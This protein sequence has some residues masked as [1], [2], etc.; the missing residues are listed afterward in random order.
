MTSQSGASESGHSAAVIRAAIGADLSD[1]ASSLQ[2]TLPA[3]VLALSGS[4]RAF[5]GDF[6]SHRRDIGAA[7]AVAVKRTGAILF[8]GSGYVGDGD[9]LW[10][11]P[12]PPHPTV[13]VASQTP[14]VPAPSP[15]DALPEEAPETA[16]APLATPGAAYTHLVIADTETGH[17]DPLLL[18]ALGQAVARGMPMALLLVGGDDTALAQTAAALERGFHIFVAAGSGGAADRVATAI[19]AGRHADP[20]VAAIVSAGRLTGAEHVHLVTIGADTAA[21]LSR[22]LVWTLDRDW[23]LKDA[24]HLFN[25]FDHSAVRLRASYERFQALILLVGVLASLLAVLSKQLGTGALRWTVVAAS[26]VL[27]GLT[28]LSGRRA[29]GK[30]WIVTRAA[31]ESVKSEIFRYRTRT[32][33][34]AD[35]MLPGRDRARRPEVLAA[36][37]GEIEGRLM[38]T[39]VGNSALPSSGGLAAAAEDPFGDNGLTPMT[40]EVYVTTR[41]Q[42]QLRY[43]RSRLR[44]YDC[45]RR[46]LQGVAVAASSAGALVAAAGGQIWV[47]VT[48]VVAAAPLAYLAHLQVEK[49]IV[50]YNQSV[51]QLSDVLRRWHARATHPPAR[52]A[53]A[54]L[55]D[56]TEA[57]LTAEHGT[58]VEEM[59]EAMH[60]L[61]DEEHGAGPS[62]EDQR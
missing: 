23:V 12:L 47:A 3:P 56:A 6:A 5:D 53:F 17:D 50:T 36:R 37:L 31:A 30:R 38:R 41:I 9:V 43:Y 45:R 62:E 21:T 8:D 26:I 40:P 34:Y 32:G 16:T 4:S 1:V 46:G 58:W 13:R 33:R 24:W 59:T 57:I 2:I 48:S 44:V 7:L 60:D 18:P 22:Q 42:D 52:R 29:A 35:S 25:N 14:A 27:T 28:A 19:Q 49:T 55:V 61:D 11:D 20:A 54:R 10:D 15:A 39:E 51:A